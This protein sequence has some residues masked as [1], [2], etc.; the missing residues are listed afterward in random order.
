M[1]PLKDSVEWPLL[2]VYDIETQD[3]TDVVLIC[4]V[5]EYGDR[6]HFSTVSDY[7]DWLFYSFKGQHVWAHAGGR[8]DHRFLIP[9]LDRRGW[10]FRAAMSGGTIVLLTATAPHIKKKIYFADSFRI[11][12]NAL[13][14]I[15]KTVALPKLD[16]DR[17]H[18]EALTEQERLDYCF[19]DCDIALKG[20][21][22]MR[23]AL[24]SVNADFAFTLASIASRW[25][26]R[27]PSVDFNRFYRPKNG[28]I[29]YDPKMVE[30]D[31]WSEPAYFGGRCEMFRRGQFKGPIYYYDVVSSY[32]WSMQ[33]DLP[34]YFQ[35][36]FPPPE[37]NSPSDIERYLSY[38]GITE[39]TVTI[40]RNRAC[41]LPIR[42]EGRLT[43]PFGKARG[44]WTNIELMA[45]L[46]RGVT[47]EP[48]MQA[49]FEAKPFLNGFVQTFYGL[50]KQ[51]KADR[52]TFR[53]YAYKILLNS[54]YGKLVETIDRSAYVTSR[55]EL[56][57]AK[58]EGAEVLSTKVPG[59]YCVQSQ[60]EGPFRHVA[61]GSYVTAYS[62]L[63]L[64]EGLEAALAA[65]GDIFYC[66]TDSIMTN[67]RLDH[68]VGGE[69]GAWEHEYTF[70]ELEL[71]LPKVYKARTDDG[72]T[73]Y[74]CKGVPIVR[75]NEPAEYPEIRWHAFKEYARTGDPDM[76]KMLSRDGLSGFVA[77][78]NA[79]T[80]FP[81]RQ[82]LLRCLKG[83][84][85]KR[86]W[87]GQDSW[88]LQL[89]EVG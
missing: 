36:Y 55:W 71:I 51:A 5:D 39:A 35:G 72:K 37:K 77:D 54:L 4:H 32:P 53:T 56:E 73:L 78:I 86:D 1:R 68:L 41:V 83:S 27:S 11:M 31:K 9:E 14:A 43:F 18:M 26:R 2:A 87:D 74:R 60:Q 58:K 62:R 69:L 79:G 21:Q 17:G 33:H 42:H 29:E 3:W 48:H 89:S 13:K 82:P 76:A 15:G 20:L 52:D 65:G 81:R 49:R 75:E 24:T 85:K 84:D 12:P 23:T 10:D 19:R 46:K 64:L 59:V 70:D 6:V 7:V 67:V 47:I 38:S 45:A 63:R 57:R 28:T 80:L 50:R 44:R 40:P 88:P 34:L 25:V 8:F 66:D 30:V 61:A 22:Y 16:V